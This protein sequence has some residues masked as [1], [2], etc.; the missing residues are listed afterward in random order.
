M[1]SLMGDHSDEDEIDTEALQAQIDLSMSFAQN[2]V[3]SWVKPSRKLPSRSRDIEVEL[4]EYM[5][6]PPRL[7]VGAPIPRTQSLS[8]ETARLKGRLIGK[9]AKRSREIEEDVEKNSSD[10]G[11]DEESRARAIKKKAKVDPFTSIKKKRRKSAHDSNPATSRPPSSQIDTE[12]SEQA[13][14]IG[15]ITEVDVRGGDR[16]LLSPERRSLHNETA[17]GRQLSPARSPTSLARSDAAYAATTP[18][19]FPAN[20]SPAASPKVLQAVDISFTATPL[21]LPSRR[22]LSQSAEIFKQPVLNLGPLSGEDSSDEEGKPRPSAPSSPK[23]KRR[24]RKKKKHVRIA[25]VTVS[26][27]FNEDVATMS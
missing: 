19:N 9:G 21:V 20:G 23:K 8:N 2:L 18:E 25:D 24:R 3:T 4:K 12:I 5:R 13:E 26:T 7:G 22:Q 10:T 16:Q 14:V 27:K 17:S 6:R 15:M 1:I 11:N